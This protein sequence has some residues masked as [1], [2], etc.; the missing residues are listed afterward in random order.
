MFPSSYRPPLSA[1]GIPTSWVYEDLERLSAG[2]RAFSAPNATFSE[3][4]FD[5]AQDPD[6]E[7]ESDSERG[8]DNSDL[9]SA[10]YMEAEDEIG[11]Q[12]DR[13]SVASVL[14]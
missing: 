12:T 2:Q 7:D 13:S 11:S 8:S 1:T 3:G 14:S 10:H 9:S 6:A 5:I 4:I